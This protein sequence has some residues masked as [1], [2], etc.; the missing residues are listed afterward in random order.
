[1]RSM[2]HEDEPF[3]K[4]YPLNAKVL[5]GSEINCE[6]LPLSEVKGNGAACLNDL[7]QL[8][9]HKKSHLEGVLYTRFR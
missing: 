1:M 6:A 5:Y 2:I 4:V 7:K 3:K 8:F 9:G